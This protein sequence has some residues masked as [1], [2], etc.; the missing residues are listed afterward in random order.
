MQAIGVIGVTLAGV[1]LFQQPPRRSAP[2]SSRRQRPAG[3]PRV[4]H[5]IRRFLTA[6]DELEQGF[7]PQLR[8]YPY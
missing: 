3:R 5:A 7:T 6:A 1:D 2:R 4:T 8:H